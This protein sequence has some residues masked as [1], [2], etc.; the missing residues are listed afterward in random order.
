MQ[1]AI[2]GWRGFRGVLYPMD[3]KAKAGQKLT[4]LSHDV[5]IPNKLYMDN[6]LEQVGKNL[7]MMKEVSWMKIRYR[8]TEPYSPWQNAVENIIGIVKSK[9]HHGMIR[10][11]VP[12]NLWNYGMVWEA[13]IYS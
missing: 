11:N 10:R 8:T 9:H 7:E 2:H 6:A 1:S 4:D 13:Q 12:F 3:L 5:G